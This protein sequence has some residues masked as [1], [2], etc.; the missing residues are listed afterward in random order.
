MKN[1]KFFISLSFCLLSVSTA[2]ADSL[3]ARQEMLCQRDNIKD[4]MQRVVRFQT[5]AFGG[6]LI[7]D[8][9][10]G[11]FYTGVYAAYEATG[12]ETFYNAAKDWCEDAGWKMSGSPFF[13]DDICSAQTFLDVYG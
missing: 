4:L 6:K 9:K 3:T 2:L 5:D 1:L 12:D 8:W 10:V 7:T 13:A 11:T